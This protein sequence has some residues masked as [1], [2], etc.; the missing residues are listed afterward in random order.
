M[1]L[2]GASSNLSMIKTLAGYPKGAFCLGNGADPYAVCPRFENPLFEG[3][4][5][6]MIICPT[7]EVC[8]TINILPQFYAAI[9][10]HFLYCFVIF[11]LI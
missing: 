4:H 11:S 10:Y 2:D 7:H 3:E 6:Y 1:V 8:W 9:K 5:I